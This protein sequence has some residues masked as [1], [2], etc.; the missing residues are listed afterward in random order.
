MDRTEHK[1]LVGKGLHKTPSR[2]TAGSAKRPRAA[3]ADPRGLAEAGGE[4]LDSGRKMSAGRG[5]PLARSSRHAAGTDPVR[6][7]GARR[8][9]RTGASEPSDPP[10][11]RRA[12]GE[13]WLRWTS[14]ALPS[15]R[16]RTDSPWQWNRGY[17]PDSY[18]RA[19]VRE[20]ARDGNEGCASSTRHGA[21]KSGPIT[22][23][24]PPAP[25]GLYRHPGRKSSS[26]ARPRPSVPLLP[27]PGR[28]RR[29][30]P[31]PRC[32]R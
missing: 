19:I 7:L 12:S 29:C 20:A 22:R 15:R 2:F 31:S 28:G 1:D 13:H 25:H 24:A 6:L 4:R 10:P 5:Q 3:A 14:K 17:S 16:L 11:S 18:S 9:E 32:P 30:A 8:R 23:A 27:D 21:E 26:P